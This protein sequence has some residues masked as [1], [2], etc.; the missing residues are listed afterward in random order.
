M[1]KVLE[2]R[3]HSSIQQYSWYVSIFFSRFNVFIIITYLV[4]FSGCSK[5][6]QSF[7]GDL[8]ALEL[9]HGTLKSWEINTNLDGKTVKNMNKA[10]MFC[11][12]VRGLIVNC[13]G[14]YFHIGETER[15]CFIEEIPDETTVIV[16]YIV[17]LFDPKT[18]GFM[19]NAPGLRMHACRS[20]R[21][22]LQS[23]SVPCLQ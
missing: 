8:S 20:E 15:K 21:S 12:L 10:Q 6:L 23:H 2:D 19:K 3:F 22:Q 9:L 14:L 4:Y 16:N 1:E 7:L 13:S 5:T 11:L 17:E 18:G